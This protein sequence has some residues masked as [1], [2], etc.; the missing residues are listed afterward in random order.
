MPDPQTERELI[1][2]FSDADVIAITINPED[3]TED[4]K[5]EYISKYEEEY[6]L[7]SS[8]AIQEPGKIAEAISDLG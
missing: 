7:P 4:E 2:S 5:K 3:L 6:D 8:D 1:R